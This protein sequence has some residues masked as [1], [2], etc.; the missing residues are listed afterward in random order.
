MKRTFPR[1]CFNPWLHTCLIFILPILIASAIY[2]W[3]TSYSVEKRVN[4][5]LDEI[6]FTFANGVDGFEHNN[7]E[8]AFAKLSFTCDA[9]D[10]ALLNSQSL[11]PSIV[12]FIQLELV[13]GKK[14]SN[15]GPAVNYHF[16]KYRS[17]FIGSQQIDIA[18]TVAA[19]DR[20]RSIAYIFHLGRQRLVVLT[21]SSVYNETLS[22]LCYGCYELVIRYRGLSAIERGLSNLDKSQILIERSRYINTWDVAE[23]VNLV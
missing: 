23:R 3:L 11:S 4:S 6:A 19:N 13:D 15:I 14:C 7:I 2:P 5:D 17:T 16:D 9:D 1:W 12:R 18:T 8:Q 20:A 21:N 22:D 10:V